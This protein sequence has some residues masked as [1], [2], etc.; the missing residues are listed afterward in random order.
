MGEAGRAGDGWAGTG[1]VQEMS[2]L[3][4]Q[5]CCES[6]TAFKNSLFLESLFKNW[7]LM[8]YL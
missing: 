2:V 3:S 7:H 8:Y 4:P 1:N 5:F 6:K